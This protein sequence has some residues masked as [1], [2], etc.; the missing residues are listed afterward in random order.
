MIPIPEWAEYRQTVRGLTGQAIKT[1][2][3]LSGLKL[4]SG[5]QTKPRTLFLA[6]RDRISTMGLLLGIWY[7]MSWYFEI[8]PNN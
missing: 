4:E 8:Q 2:L 1:S 6:N 5:N 7:L 3:R